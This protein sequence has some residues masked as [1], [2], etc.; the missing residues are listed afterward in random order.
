VVQ[1]GAAH[2]MMLVEAVVPPAGVDME[3]GVEPTAGAELD[4]ESSAGADEVGW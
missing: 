2:A 4:R 1:V 3:L